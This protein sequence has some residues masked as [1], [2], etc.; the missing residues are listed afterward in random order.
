MD[1]TGVHMPVFLFLIR[2]WHSNR[3]LL[4]FFAYSSTLKKDGC[5]SFTQKY[6]FIREN[7]PWQT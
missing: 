5:T 7:K 6:L 4:S 3:R 2:L 1:A